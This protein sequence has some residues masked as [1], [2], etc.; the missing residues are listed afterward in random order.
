MNILQFVGLYFLLLFSFLCTVRAGF[1]QQVHIAFGGNP[2]QYVISWVSWEMTPNEVTSEVR[3]GTNSNNLNLNA[4]GKPFVFIDSC[5]T[6]RTMHNVVL[7]NL[8]PASTI[9]YQAR[10]SINN[11]GN[12][13]QS[14]H[15]RVVNPQ[16]SQ[17]RFAIYGDFGTFFNVTCLD[18]LIEQVQGGGIEFVAHA[19]DIAYNLNF[20]CGQV[21]DVYM[22]AVQAV[23]AY[24]PYMWGIGN[25]EQDVGF[26]YMNYLNRYSGNIYAAQ[27][28]G[29]GTIRWFSWNTQLVHFICVDSDPWIYPELFSLAAPQYQFLQTDLQNVNRTNTPWIV[30]FG[31]RAMYCT[32]NTD[33]ECN[34]EAENIRYGFS[35]QYFPLE[36][37]LL[38]YGVDLYL[39]GHTHHYERT[40][41]VIKNVTQQKNY[42]NPKGPVHIQSGIVGVD[43][44]DHFEVPPA[45]WEAFR[46]LTYTRGYGKMTILSATKMMYQQITA[47]GE[48]MDEFFVTQNKHGPFV[49]Y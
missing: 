40:Y 11:T 41:P 19:G 12:W 43:G 15:F 18:Q 35:G 31:H 14:F 13:T 47:T 36:K 8:Q 39:A 32:K 49:K 37:L 2:S 1:P 16:Q 45:D 48:L 25:H 28:S 17:L 26:S 27:A 30:M 21:G 38:E 24:V 20:E 29:S 34:Q 3:Y 10:C 42:V 9:Y 5:G 7:N 33:P 4:I 6:Q 22:N 23:A 46:D 44:Q